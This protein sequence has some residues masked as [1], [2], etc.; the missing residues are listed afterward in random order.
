MANN[1]NKKKRVQAARAEAKAKKARRDM[2]LVIGGV[3]V[4][5][6][7][8]LGAAFVFG[9]NDTGVTTATAWDLPSLQGDVDGDGVEDR[10]T[11][12]DFEGQPLVVN[13]FAS[14]CT[15]CENEL[16][17]FKFVDEQFADELN[18][19]YVNSNETGNWE[20]MAE[21]TGILDGRLVKDI[22]G[23]NG[24]GLYRS[25]GGR[26]GMPITAFYDAEGNVVRVDQGELSSEALV[27]RLINLY[28]I[29]PN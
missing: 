5:A 26:G 14:W 22:N 29:E 24:N 16:P 18:V 10:F 28:G 8:I 4:I 20:P 15:N 12:S 3:A 23:S 1:S 19:V 17:R 21:R 25:L 2:M 27:A 13:F 7:G 6:L 9:G 11:L